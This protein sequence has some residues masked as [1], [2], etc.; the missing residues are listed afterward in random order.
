MSSRRSETPLRQTFCDNVR[1]VSLPVVRGTY[2]TVTYKRI[3]DETLD[4]LITFVLVYPDK[5]DVQI[6]IT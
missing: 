4:T 1:R 5:R 3:E 6:F 2:V